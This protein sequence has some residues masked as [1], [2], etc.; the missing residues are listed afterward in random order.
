LEPDYWQQ[1]WAE[2]RIG[3]HQPKVNALLRQY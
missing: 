1:R 3:W 2:G